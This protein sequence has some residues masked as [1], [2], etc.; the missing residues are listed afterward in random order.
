MLYLVC[1][2]GEILGNKQLVYE[3]YMKKICENLNLDFDMVSQGLADKNEAYTYASGV[4]GK[5]K[6]ERVGYYLLMPKLEQPK[7]LVIRVYGGFQKSDAQTSKYNGKPDAFSK[8]LLGQGYAIAYLNLA[9]LHFNNT[10]QS[11]MPENI[12]N[13]T[14]EGITPV[15][16]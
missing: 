3:E 11:Q 1:T 9:D 12:F 15:L 8:K 2:C 14:L 16:K 5:D 6:L 10:F 7:G 13:G 4:Y